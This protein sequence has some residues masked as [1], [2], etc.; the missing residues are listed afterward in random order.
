MKWKI[1]FLVALVVGALGGSWLKNL[2]GFVIVAYEK[3]SYEM[4]LWVAVA[5]ILFVW[6]L[7][8][9]LGI[10]IR[11]ILSNAGKMKSWRGGRQWKLARK[12][13][14][15]GMLAYAEG[16]WQKSEKTMVAAAKQSDTK[17]VNYLIAAQAA[18]HQQS[19]GQASVERRDAYLR[20]A[21][22]LEPNAGVA[23][24]ITQA[25]LQLD[26]YQ[27][28]QALATLSELNVKSP[29]HPFVIKLL[30]VAHERL[31]DWHSIVDLLPSIKKLRIYNEEKLSTLEDQSIQKLLSGIA[32]T[33]ELEKLKDVWQQLPSHLRKKELNQLF[34][35]KMLINFKQMAEAEKLLKPHFKKSIDNIEKTIELY[36]EIK[37]ENAN[38]QFNFL[39]NWYSQSDQAPNI[40]YLALGKVAFNAELWGKAR[41]YLERNLQTNPTAESYL[42]MAKTLGHLNDHELASDCYK[43]GLEFVMGEDSRNKFSKLNKS[44]P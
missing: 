3:T 11:S 41:F 34:F 42:I 24:G 26:N 38:Q 29:N 37:L 2:P 36:G 19:Q 12:Q 31:N 23:I 16:R 22:K 4:R 8:L 9:L 44:N 6:S 10:F 35:I 1:V 33:N 28:E 39:E 32:E 15:Q 40:I 27:N 25:Q 43:K 13:T 7:F 14:I 17:L 18:Q 5:I 30:C 20:A 21:H